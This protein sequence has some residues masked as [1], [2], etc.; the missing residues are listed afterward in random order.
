MRERGSEIVK[1]ERRSGLTF[2]SNRNLERLG[3]NSEDYVALAQS[4]LCKK[5]LRTLSSAAPK[6][7]SI[8]ID[9]LNQ[10]LLTGQLT[11]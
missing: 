6:E 2:P 5:R 7:E 8:R 1:I 3:R 11:R 4:G 10:S 9:L